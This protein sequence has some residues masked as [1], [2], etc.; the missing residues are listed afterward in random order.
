MSSQQTGVC[1]D[2]LKGGEIKM[3]RAIQKQINL[4]ARKLEA[5]SALGGG[6]H[7]RIK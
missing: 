5:L 7:F 3:T 4:R 1:K 2:E 6:V